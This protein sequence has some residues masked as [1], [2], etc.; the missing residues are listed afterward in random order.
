MENSKVIKAYLELK[1][2]IKNTSNTIGFNTSNGKRLVIYN[3]DY[4]RNQEECRVIDKNLRLVNL[5]ED[6]HYTDPMK[7][8]QYYFEDKG[9]VNIDSIMI[10]ETVETAFNWLTSNLTEKSSDITLIYDEDL[11]ME[12][13]R[14]K[15]EDVKLNHVKDID[16]INEGNI[17]VYINRR[18]NEQKILKSRYTKTGVIS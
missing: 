11:N 13:T 5:N 15:I 8:I 16:L 12:G 9:S 18:T 6:V 1:N 17:L 3:I 10:F 7:L 4:D 2:R 14:G